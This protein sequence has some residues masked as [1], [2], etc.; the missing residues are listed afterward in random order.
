[1]PAP[2]VYPA[3]SDAPSPTTGSRQRLWPEPTATSQIEPAQLPPAG[4]FAP[5][6]PVHP[7]EDQA[8]VRLE[9][10]EHGSTTAPGGLQTASADDATTNPPLL[11]LD[12]IG[13]QAQTS[14]ESIRRNPILSVFSRDPDQ[15]HP[16][17]RRQT[18]LAGFL[19]LVLLI[20]GAVTFPRSWGDPGPGIAVETDRS[21][22]TADPAAPNADGV[23]PIV[24]SSPTGDEGANRGAIAGTL[25][26][27]DR[28][29]GRPAATTSTSGSAGGSDASTTT[30]SLGTETSATV[31]PSGPSTS[32]PGA[33]PVAG[34]TTTRPDPGGP[35]TSLIEVSTSSTRA[36][37][38]SSSTT[39]T[40][41]TTTTRPAT[42]RRT[43]TTA[44]PTT[45]TR[46]STTRRTTTTRPTTTTT[47]PT[48][49]T[50]EATTT[51][52]EA[53]TTTTEATTTT[54]N[55]DTTSSTLTESTGR[56]SLPGQCQ[57][58]P[59]PVDCDPEP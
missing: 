6:P 27:R 8:V 7:I 48:T 50:T 46:P 21:G 3:R 53:T 11:T 2:P 55:Q 37:V 23:G 38:V 35:T 34:C 47:R 10:L 58:D 31:G 52:T 45:T 1:M 36:S 26:S 29:S 42:T 19:L 22:T 51:T 24:D 13:Q 15:A 5:S 4:L 16:L 44:R 9:G 28:S 59:P 49:T 41:A 54:E 17:Y 40:R 18:V 56:P 25:G 20:V 33:I 30:T 32:C 39:T 14:L 43:T 12:H 57:G